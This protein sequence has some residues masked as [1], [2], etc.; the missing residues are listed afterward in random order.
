MATFVPCPSLHS[1]NPCIARCGSIFYFAG[2]AGQQDNSKIKSD[3]A[4]KVSS[5]KRASLFE[6]STSHQNSYVT[7]SDFLI[8]VIIWS[9]C[10]AACN[11]ISSS[12]CV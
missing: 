12:T 11:F 10:L 5:C 7:A 8:S 6:Y 4:R 1:K 2:Q 3:A 9:I